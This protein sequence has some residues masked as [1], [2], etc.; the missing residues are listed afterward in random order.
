LAKNL[1]FPTI[2]SHSGPSGTILTI[3][4]SRQ[5]CQGFVPGAED[6]EGPLGSQIPF[7]NEALQDAFGIA[8]IP[9]KAAGKF[10]FPA[11]GMLGSERFTNANC[12]AI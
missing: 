11:C 3:W 12:A 6:R 7:L 4:P 9:D 2:G 5:L 1:A 10:V 8:T